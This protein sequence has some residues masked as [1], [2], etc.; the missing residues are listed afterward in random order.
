MG[1]R[2]MNLNDLDVFINEV[3]EGVDS[4][5][6]K[7][8]GPRHGQGHGKGR[9]W[10]FSIPNFPPT[11]W[12]LDKDRN[13][14][15]DFALAGYSREEIDISFQGDWMVLTITP[16]KEEENHDITSIHNGIRKS[17]ARNKYYVPHD[18]Y[19][20]DKVKASF[21][22]GLLKVFIPSKEPEKARPVDIE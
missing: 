16:I 14:Y 12:K 3:L 19:E 13:F 7:G 9:D 21:K 15:F 8:F 17:S 1:P 10:N 2:F 11:D 20:S 4:E 6:G 5:F 22:D 18:K